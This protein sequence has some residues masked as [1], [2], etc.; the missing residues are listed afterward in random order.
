MHSHNLQL[1]NPWNP[2]KISTPTL[3][4]GAKNRQQGKYCLPPRG[5]SCA[6]V[7]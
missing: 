3:R 5:F 1:N 7:S 2:M 4:I 6:F